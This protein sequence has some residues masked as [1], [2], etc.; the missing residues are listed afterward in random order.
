[1]P[2]LHLERVCANVSSGVREAVRVIMHNR[3]KDENLDMGLFSR[4][5]VVTSKESRVE[6]VSCLKKRT[7]KDILWFMILIRLR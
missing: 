4:F 7:V 6:T 5:Y 3:S 2:E 1:M